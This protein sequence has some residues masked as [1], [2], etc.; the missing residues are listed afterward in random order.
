[1]AAG[2]KENLKRSVL[3]RG[4]DVM[5][6]RDIIGQVL[7]PVYFL[8]GQSYVIYFSDVTSAVCL[9]Q[10][11]VRCNFSGVSGGSH[12]SDVT[13]VCLQVYDCLL[14]FKTLDHR[15]TLSDA[16]GLAYQVS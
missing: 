13:S 12:W 14:D 3:H 6:Y 7:P 16:S 1:M 15:P 10:S 9:G 8:Q 4:N 5:F 11:L 2:M